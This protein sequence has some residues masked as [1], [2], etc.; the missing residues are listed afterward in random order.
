MRKAAGGGA[1]RAGDGLG[2]VHAGRKHRLFELEYRRTIALTFD[3]VIN[4]VAGDHHIA[5]E[6]NRARGHRR[7]GSDVLGAQCVQ[8]RASTLFRLLL[9]LDEAFG[10]VERHNVTVLSVVGR[11]E[12]GKRGDAVKQVRGHDRQAGG[13]I[14]LLRPEEKILAQGLLLARDEYRGAV[15]L[16][17]RDAI[18][19]SKARLSWQRRRW[20]HGSVGG[21]E[22]AAGGEHLEMTAGVYRTD[23]VH[24]VG[25]NGDK[26]ALIIEPGAY[27][28]VEK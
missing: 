21:I 13:V 18:G 12:C 2:A 11:G 9:G 5:Q 24:L 20:R 22:L 16:H 25:V 15:N 19:R 14:S 28:V 26:D 27:V 4:I 1:E 10:A 6:I 7:P 8:D 17:R 3:H 23:L